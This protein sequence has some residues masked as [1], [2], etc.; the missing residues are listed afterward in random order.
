MLQDGK[1]DNYEQK[2]TNYAQKDDDY[3]EKDMNYSEKDKGYSEKDGNYVKKDGNY[4]W[5]DRLYFAT[6][7]A[8]KISNDAW[9]IFFAYIDGKD[10]IQMI[11]Y[12]IYYSTQCLNAS[13]GCQHLMQPVPPHAGIPH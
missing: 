3:S 11:K 4:V 1:D 6:S 8:F 13:G 12:E 7:I 10:Y 5:A 9:G 2:D